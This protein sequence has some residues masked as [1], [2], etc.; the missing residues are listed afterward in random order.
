MQNGWTGLAQYP[1][2]T[3]KVPALF[4]YLPISVAI[5]L[6]ET[7]LAPS[8]TLF[9]DLEFEAPEMFNADVM[10]AENLLSLQQAPYM[11]IAV[12]VRKCCVRSKLANS[13]E[14]ATWT[15]KL[16]LQ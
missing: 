7:R 13:P 4:Q 14:N 16:K 11:T 8:A 9:I 12:P 6:R 10:I 15:M 1:F 5:A 2:Q 3:N